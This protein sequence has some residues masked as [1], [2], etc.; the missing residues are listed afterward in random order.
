V[1]G[2]KDLLRELGYRRETERSLE[3]YEDTVP[4][5]DI[6]KVK[7]I[8]AELLVAKLEMEGFDREGYRP[9][10]L[11]QPPHA[12][13]APRPVDMFG[14]DSLQVHGS[15]VQTSSAHTLP[16]E[17]HTFDTLTAQPHIGTAEP[18]KVSVRVD[19]AS[20]LVGAC[21]NV[22]M[23]FAWSSEALTFLILVFVGKDISY[24]CM[25][26]IDSLSSE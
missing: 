1:V 16:Q 2:A 3:F 22:C 5:S 6:P 24:L 8:T 12:N 15:D 17:S 21:C 26:A 10:Q 4:E 18:Y 9:W 25:L 20:V 14:E 13:A 19:P 23:F 7:Q 11:L